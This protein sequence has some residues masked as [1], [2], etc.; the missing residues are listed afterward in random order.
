MISIYP[1]LLPNLQV[2]L[3]QLALLTQRVAVLAALPSRVSSKGRPVTWA[4]LPAPEL[5]RHVVHL[6]GQRNCSGLTRLLLRTWFRKKPELRVAV[7]NAL[8][9]GHYPLPPL[10]DCAEPSL[11]NLH[12]GESDISKQGQHFYFYPKGQPV[13]GTAEASAE[14]ATLMAHLLGWSVLNCVPDEVPPGEESLAAVAESS[15]T[16]REITAAVMWLMPQLPPALA[17]TARQGIL[18]PELATYWPNDN[19][20]TIVSSLQSMRTTYQEIL[21]LPVS[22]PEIPVSL[23]ELTRT[24]ETMEQQL[25]GHCIYDQ[26]RALA[27]ALLAR[28]DDLTHRQQPDFAPLATL[29]ERTAALRARFD[30]EW[31]ADHNTMPPPWPEAWALVQLARAYRPLLRLVEHPDELNQLDETSEAYQH[32]EAHTPPGVLNALL[33]RKLRLGPATR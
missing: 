18:S 10:A 31:P 11:Y 30:T 21:H 16:L 23:P 15:G 5:L 6:A 33:L 2:K 24:L 7:Y 3:A 26:H 4:S 14:E 8:D 17:D 25:V 20:P 28:V 12:L 13:P 29:R 9:E 22:P 19:W 1:L 27:L 32:L